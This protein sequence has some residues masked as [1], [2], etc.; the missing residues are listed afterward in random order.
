M[1]EYSWINGKRPCARILLDICNAIFDA[2]FDVMNQE[3]F[4]V[5]RKLL[6][7]YGVQTSD[8]GKTCIAAVTDRTVNRGL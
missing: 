7:V 8:V 3:N 2:R 6:F 4:A 5:S 1:I